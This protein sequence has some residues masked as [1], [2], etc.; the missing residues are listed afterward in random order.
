MTFCFEF[1]S[2]LDKPCHNIVVF[3]SNA[4]A[5]QVGKLEAAREPKET[6]SER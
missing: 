3:D 6:G 4:F 1:S 2:V 5:V